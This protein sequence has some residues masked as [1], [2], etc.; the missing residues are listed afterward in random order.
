MHMKFICR[1]FLTTI[2]FVMCIL[3]QPCIAAAPD[4]NAKSMAT[5]IELSLG[6]NSYRADG[7]LI[8]MDTAPVMENDRVLVPLRVVAESLGCTVE[9]EHAA[10]QVT[11]VK[12]TRK[13][14]LS[15]GNSRAYITDLEYTREIQLD[16]V[17]KIINDRTLVPVRFVAES[18]GCQVYWNEA[19]R[20]VLIVTV[21]A[22][23]KKIGAST[24]MSYLQESGKSD[25]GMVVAV[26]DSGV[27]VDHI[28]LQNRIVQ[29]HNIA[30]HSSD[31]YDEIGHGTKVAGVIV[32]CTP[33]TVKIMPIKVVDENGKYSP[34]TIAQAIDFAV[35]HGAK[36]INISLNA[37][38]EPGNS[39]VTE[40][41][42]EAVRHGC[43]VVAAAGNGIDDVL[44]YTP[45]NAKGAIVVTAINR[46]NVFTNSN[47]GSTV[48][49][50]APG[51][52][53]F[54]TVPN[55][56]YG[57]GNGTSMS[58]PYVSA[59]VAMICMDIPGIT[60]AEIRN[61]LLDY[62][63]DLGEPG[64]D[65]WYGGGLLDL[66][67]YVVFRKSGIIGD[68]TKSTQE[69]TVALDKE[70]EAFRTQKLQ[71]HLRLYG[72]FWNPMFAN[73][74]NAE[75]QRLYRANNYFAAGYYYE[76]ALDFYPDNTVKNNLAYMIRRGEY[77]SYKYT[78]RQLLN[79]SKAGGCLYAYVNDA[80]L[81]A[82]KKQWNEADQIMEEF[83][84]QYADTLGME[85][86]IQ[87]WT[88]LSYQKDAE[89]DLVLGWLMRYHVYEDRQHTQEE[90]M[91]RALEKY[92][93]LPDW[94]KIPV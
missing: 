50:A 52:E 14:I 67:Q 21:G 58:A 37:A 83:C 88:S 1:R 71:E 92:P 5:F 31:V 44:N 75:A 66:S 2:I 6:Q 23:G 90:Y 80:L 25:T 51:T 48:V 43:I 76:K 29:A 57:V 64:W 70:I 24:M 49:V 53:V 18:L 62:S 65:Q 42:A 38:V 22:G 7:Q 60:P 74:L 45:S 55:N 32:N 16:T 33:E 35:D 54:T 56:S 87:T 61:L 8:P 10:Q 59:A 9:W 39:A 79:Q 86:I 4:S 34:D 81:A 27:D 17:P 46:N 91:E 89:G 63:T 94:M 73:D 77:V 78:I 84:A 36:V 12:D 3:A 69:K 72:L 68:L 47:Y 15:I 40:A 82:S 19:E 13:I 85:Q 28:Y 20:K 30:E 41:V 26:I 93:T 11:I